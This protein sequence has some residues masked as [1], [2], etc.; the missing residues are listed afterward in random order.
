MSLTDSSFWTPYH[1]QG[2]ILAVGFGA[3]AVTMLVFFFRKLLRC[4]VQVDAEITR[5]LH[6]TSRN[7]DGFETDTYAPEYTYYYNGMRYTKTPTVYTSGSQYEIG[8]VVRLRIDPA[9]P[10]T[11]FDAKR[12]ILTTLPIP[13]IMVIFA[14]S[15]IWMLIKR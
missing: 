15:G 6:S 11:V 12:E 3:G 13:G 7:S 4:S 9:E 14:A 5:L 8:T 10:E 1:I 2:L